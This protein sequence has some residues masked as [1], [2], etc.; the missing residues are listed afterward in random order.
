MTHCQVLIT[1]GN[2]D[3]VDEGIEFVVRADKAVLDKWVV[4]TFLS[5]M[6]LTRRV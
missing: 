2:L 4:M 1:N 5:G 3:L 6:D